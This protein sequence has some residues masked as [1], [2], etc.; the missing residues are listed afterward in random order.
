MAKHGPHPWVRRIARY[1]QQMFESDNVLKRASAY[2]FD[3]LRLGRMRFDEDILTRSIVRNAPALLCESSVKKLAELYG[4]SL[5]ARQG[6][7][8]LCL[9]FILLA[10]AMSLQ[11]L[12]G[13]NRFLTTCF[14]VIGKRPRP[15]TSPEFDPLNGGMVELLV[16][17]HSLMSRDD[18]RATGKFPSPLILNLYSH[19]HLDQAAAELLWLLRFYLNNIGD[20]G[21]TDGVESCDEELVTWRVPEEC[22]EGL[23]WICSPE[24]DPLT[25]P[26]HA[27]SAELIDQHFDDLMVLATLLWS[28]IV[29]EPRYDIRPGG[30]DWFKIGDDVP[31]KWETNRAYFVREGTSL[32]I[33]TAYHQMRWQQ[34]QFIYIG[35]AMDWGDIESSVSQDE[36]YRERFGRRGRLLFGSLAQLLAYHYFVCIPK[37]SQRQREGGEWRP[38]MELYSSTVE[39]QVRCFF[40]R[41]QPGWKPSEEA[42]ER[43]V[44]R[45]GYLPEG[46]TFVDEYSRHRPVLDDT[47]STGDQLEVEPEEG[48]REARISVSINSLLSWIT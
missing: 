39:E 46:Y 4:R 34:G 28:E 38:R 23:R 41:L 25:S 14:D 37:S 40:R 17:L 1:P 16:N 18:L 15:M 20:I 19:A 33:A 10:N 32:P 27:K 30:A 47:R 9:V 35:A 36:L 31:S 45:L 3:L 5:N 8:G 42:R 11:G 13:C 12:P 21:W 44:R 22:Q 29:A 26:E 6:E 43:A 7:H 48:E 24:Y 2:L